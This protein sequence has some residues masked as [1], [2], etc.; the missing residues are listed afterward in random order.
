MQKAKILIV[1]DDRIILDSL[2]EYL[3]L[4]GYE[5]TGAESFTAAVSKL[6]TRQFALVVTDVNMPDGDGFEILSTVR[7]HY[8][9]TVV[10]VITGY[11]TIESA[12]E[13]IKMGAYDYLTKPV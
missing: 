1:D 3:T 5:T 7:K 8:P 13:A 2:C 11:G 6:K 10:I 12:V 4:E 9:K